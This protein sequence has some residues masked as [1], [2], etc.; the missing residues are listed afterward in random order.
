MPRTLFGHCTAA[1]LLCAALLFAIPV[2]AQT[3]YGSIVGTVADPSHSVI[4]SAKIAL[5]NTATGERRTA[6][7]GADGSYRFVN[8]L[9]GTYKLEVEAPGF[10][11]YTQDQIEIN[12]EA[13]VRADV[14][15][16]LGSVEQTVEVTGAAPLL[17]TE[18]ATVGQVVNTRS[19]EN[20]P[21]NGRNV[22]NLAAN[23]AGVVPQ[24]GAMGSAT[25]KNVFAPGNYQ[26][27]GGTAN[28]GASY[29]DGVPVNITYGNITA[30]VPS[31]D[32]VSEFRVQSSNNTAEYGRY[33]G[34]VINLASKAGSN[35]IHGSAYEFLRNR[36]L[37]AANFFA[38]KAGAGK[39][40]FVQNQFGA[41]VGG[42]IFK[43]KT[44]FFFGY[45]GYRARQ[46]NLFSYSVPT[47]AELKGDFSGY[48]NASGAQIPIYDPLTQCGQYN[49]PACGT[50]TAQRAPFPGNIIPANRFSPVAVKILA[51]PE[52]ALP[53]T[54]GQ[55][56]TNNLNYA[57][58][59][60]TGGDNDQI[61]VR[62]DHQLSQ[63][64]RL[65]A[66]EEDTSKAWKLTVGDWREREHWDD[67]VAAYEDA[68]ARCGTSWAPWY[69]VP[70][71]TKWYRDYVIARTI[72]EQLEPHE[73][74]WE[75][76][77][78]DLGKQR[79]RELQEADI[80]ER[81]GKNN[82]AAKPKK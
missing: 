63:K 51:F 36:A 81:N 38:N 5:T 48:L 76:A 24:G 1:A 50:S 12:V 7:S 68:L 34:G 46:G 27:G 73:R 77:L 3:F 64:Q 79:L 35:V 61:N 44:F 80:P 37:N 75:R 16:Q 8:L 69:I 49:N 28:Q 21:L 2:V 13:T 11:H 55:P 18:T 15:M 25:G 54:A 60:A 58:N 56:F 6:T 82:G 40:A 59:A 52:Y 65:L 19:V 67:Y 33:T 39:A 17:Q 71:D 41:D 45:E 43:D 74:A 62:G 78:A 70:A 29:Y 14:A 22:M 20:L 32:A 31:Q 72:V 47:P 53:N 4:P 9:P 42:P 66:R 30:L 23:V 10:Q 57:R 26:I